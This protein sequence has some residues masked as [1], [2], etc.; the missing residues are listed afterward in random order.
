MSRIHTTILLAGIVLVGA[1]GLKAVVAGTDSTNTVLVANGSA[2]APK[3]WT[4]TIAAV[5]PLQN[6]SAPAPKPW[7]D[8]IVAVKPLQNG[9]A[10]A[11]KPWTDTLAARSPQSW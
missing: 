3:P 6:G 1:M 11:P 10:P 5:N 8:T 4:D 9:S 7:T 2:P